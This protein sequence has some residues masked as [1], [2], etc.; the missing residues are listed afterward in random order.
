MSGIAP[1][2]P[3][4]KDQN[5]GFAVTKT[6]KENIKQALKMLVLTNPGERIM[7]PEYGVGLRTYLFESNIP[8]TRSRIVTKLTEQINEYI[9]YVQIIDIR[10]SDDPRLKDNNALHMT[11]VYTAAGIVGN[12]ELDLY[13]ESLNPYW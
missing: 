4:V 6:I 2:M 11:I 3:L 8:I 9:P 1:K 7:L 12:Q 13:L 10:I 5:D